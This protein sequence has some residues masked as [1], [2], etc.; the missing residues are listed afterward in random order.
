MP[1][2]HRARWGIIYTSVVIDL[3]QLEVGQLPAELAVS[4]ITIAELAA[5]PHA[6]SDTQERACHQHRLERAETFFDPP[7]FNRDALRACGRIYA[8]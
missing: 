7:P 8:S 1:D 2:A 4:A 3:E 6:T 5:A